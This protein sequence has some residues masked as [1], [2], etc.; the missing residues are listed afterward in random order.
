M[1]LNVRTARSEVGMERM[2]RATGGAAFVPRDDSDLPDIFRRIAAEIRS[3][4][5]IQ[6]Y[7]NDKSGGTAFR[8]IAVT[9]PAHPQLR[10]RAREGYYPKTK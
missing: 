2:A 3:Q 6:Y 5:I 8:R 1:H 10:V 4:Y 9:T 7:S